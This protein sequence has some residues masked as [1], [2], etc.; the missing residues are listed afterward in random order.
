MLHFIRGGPGLKNTIAFALLGPFLF[1]YFN[2]K[3]PKR[4]G[5]GQSSNLFDES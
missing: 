3:S 2:S 1:V 5:E 4:G